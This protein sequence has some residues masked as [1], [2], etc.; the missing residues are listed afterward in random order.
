MKERAHL[1]NG[2]AIVCTKKSAEHMEAVN[3][4]IAYN[5]NLDCTKF[6]VLKIVVLR[7]PDLVAI[8]PLD[9]HAVRRANTA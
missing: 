1:S 2:N 9:F 8:L 6:S 4:S 7:F 5:L 3:V